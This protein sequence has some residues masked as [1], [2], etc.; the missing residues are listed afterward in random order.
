[1]IQ[2][3]HKSENLAKEEQ[4]ESKM[5]ETV[6]GKYESAVGAN[7]VR[8]P[9]KYRSFL[10]ERFVATVGSDGCFM[11]VPYQNKDKL[12]ENYTKVSD[13][14]VS[15]MK[16]TVRAFNQLVEDIELDAQGRMTITDQLKKICTGLKLPT[17]AIVFCG[18]GD[19]IEAWPKRTYEKMF[20]GGVNADDFDALIA[21]L[22]AQLGQED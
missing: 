2:Y 14:F 22:K 6:Y 9:A 12:L 20:G 18:M 3:E 15:K 8:I 11:L 17:E 1:M 13:P 10:G 5:Q 7:R 16:D 4:K 21:K 19:Y